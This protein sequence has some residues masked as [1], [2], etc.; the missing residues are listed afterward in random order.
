MQFWHPKVT[1]QFGWS[2]LGKKERL[3]KRLECDFNYLDG[4]FVVMLWVKLTTKKF[5]WRQQISDSSF[6]ETRARSW[7][8]PRKAGSGS[9]RW[10]M[11][12]P[13]RGPWCRRGWPCSCRDLGQT[14]GRAS[15]VRRG[16]FR[17]SASLRRWT[18]ARRIARCSKPASPSWLKKPWST[19]ETW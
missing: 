4:S 5:T 17:R 8:P 19:F 18:R 11:P 10:P 6:G 16:F 7:G 3:Q 1:P 15:G 2:D 13:T 12:T 9:A 14:W